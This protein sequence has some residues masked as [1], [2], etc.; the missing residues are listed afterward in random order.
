DAL[1]RVVDAGA[2]DDRVGPREVDVLEDAEAAL[3]RREG[4]VAGDAVLGDDDQLAGRDVAHEGRADDVERAGLR[5]QD[6]GVAELAED[7]GAYAQRIAHADQR[8][9]DQRDERIGAL[10][11]PQRIDH[12]IDHRV[13]G[14]GRDQVHDDLGVGGGLEKRTALL[15]LLANLVV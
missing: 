5:R 4:A 13:P 3:G 2:L 9:V 15:Q 14:A 1:A 6:P 12:A 11:L 10:D 8:I 7:Q